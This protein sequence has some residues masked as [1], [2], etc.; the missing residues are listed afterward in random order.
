MDDG[1]H[2]NPIGKLTPVRQHPPFQCGRRRIVT[3][4]LIT[5]ADG[6]IWAEQLDT[7]PEI[8]YQH[9]VL[10][11]ASLPYANPGDEVRRWQR[12]QG[13]VRLEVEA[14]RAFHPR[15]GDYVDVGLPFGPKPRLVLAF[16]N[17][18]ALRHHTPEIDVG[19][20][21][22]EFVK[23]IGLCLDGRSIRMVKEQLARLAAAEIRMAF[24]SEEHV[25][26][27]NTHIVG[28]FDLWFPKDER[29]RVLWP[30]TV[31]LDPRYYESLREHAVPLD[32]GALSRLA[33]SAVALDVYAWLAQRLYRIRHDK[34]AFIPWPALKIQFGADYGR[35]RKFRERFLHTLARVRAEY[36]TARIDVDERGMTLC[37]SPPPI[38]GRRWLQVATRIKEP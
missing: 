28:E 15:V 7:S 13:A 8:T 33:D 26:Q 2:G 37:F 31:I 3:K 6:S 19:N 35:I 32:R 22:T 25:R 18:Y 20:S 29:Q 38:P 1:E 10:C 16:L 12:G 27:V 34:P 5:T 9:T 14:G 24:A 17:S 4:A 36:R 30:S 21:L 11:Q 23:E